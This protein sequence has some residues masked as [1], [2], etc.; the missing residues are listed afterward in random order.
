M[1]IN[2]N[3]S[4]YSQ[5]A[6]ELFDILNTNRSGK[7][8]EIL[9]ADEMAQAK[10]CGLSA[11]I[12]DFNSES[13]VSEQGFIAKYIEEAQTESQYQ[14]R[15]EQFE[16]KCANIK[17]CYEDLKNYKNL[18]F[19]V[20]NEE[21]IELEVSYNTITKVPQNG[22]YTMFN[23][24]KIVYNNGAYSCQGHEEWGNCKNVFEL[25]LYIKDEI[26]RTKTEAL[27]HNFSNA[28]TK[29]EKFTAIKDF[30][31]DL[32]SWHGGFDNDFLRINDIK[33]RRKVRINGIDIYYEVN[34]TG[35]SVKFDYAR[36][37]EQVKL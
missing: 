18:Q 26:K 12:F 35:Y 28:K 32:Y 11:L 9:D 2:P 16:E 8:K 1:S 17:E 30:V 22:M 23:G 19:C 14:V 6:K 25:Q 13:T 27:N 4:Q 5:K 10:K 34:P 37:Y 3:I 33:G 24:Y 15:M 36:I 31:D 7:S 29:E 21:K 20:N